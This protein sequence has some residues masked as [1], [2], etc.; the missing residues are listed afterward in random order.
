VFAIPA[1][2]ATIL[3]A[4]AFSAFLPPEIG[5]FLLPVT[6]IVLP[7]VLALI[8]NPVKA[9]TEQADRSPFTPDPNNDK[10]ILIQGWTEDELRQILDDFV[11]GDI[12]D[13]DAFRVEVRQHFEDSFALTFP[14]DIHPDEFI[15]LINYL[16]YPVDFD[17]AGRSIIVAG[18]TTLNSDFDGLPT[19]LAGQK[20][21][22]YLPEH[23]EEHDVVFLQTE[24]GVTMAKSFSQAAWHKVDDVR[25]SS[26]VTSLQYSEDISP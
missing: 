20:A 25:L 14:E 21:L 9:D 19:S 7:L 15:S 3:A 1:I 8:A 17:L 26:A 5:F 24:A 12:T 23:D 13:F 22:L 11:D 16:A 10:A 6:V 18:K 4:V 2:I